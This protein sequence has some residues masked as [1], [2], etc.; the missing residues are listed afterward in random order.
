MKQSYKMIVIVLL[1]CLMAACGQK[2]KVF[3][4]SI[5]TIGT[6]ELLINCSKEVTKGESDVDSIGYLCRVL[7]NEDTV[8]QNEQGEPVQLSELTTSDVVRITPV[9]PK[10]VKKGKREFTAKEIVLLKDKP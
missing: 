6:N 10:N 2:I 9:K 4:D 5:D 8:I 3:E 7:I 1:C